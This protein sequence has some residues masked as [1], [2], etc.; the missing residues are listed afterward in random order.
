MPLEHDPDTHPHSY[1]LAETTH[2]LIAS[3]SLIDEGM[4]SSDSVVVQ[5]TSVEEIAVHRLAHPSRE[6]ASS[7]GFYPQKWRHSNGSLGATSG[8]SSTTARS[9]PPNCWT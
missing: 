2:A 4:S 7:K 1:T 5:A 3:D 9:L 6:D 8:T